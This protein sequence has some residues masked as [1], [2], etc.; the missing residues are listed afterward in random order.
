MKDKEQEKMRDLLVLAKD[1]ETQ[2][3]IDM[4]AYNWE[5][6]ASRMEQITKER[7]QGLFDDNGV[8]ATA[9]FNRMERVGT[10]M[11]ALKDRPQALL[12][13]G[14]REQLNKMNADH[15]MDIEITSL[16]SP[17]KSA[18]MKIETPTIWLRMKEMIEKK[19]TRTGKGDSFV[20]KLL[21]SRYLPNMEDEEAMDWMQSLSNP[22]PPDE[23]TERAQLEVMDAMAYFG[24]NIGEVAS[25]AR[26]QIGMGL[27]IMH[28]MTLL[29]SELLDI[30]KIADEDVDALFEEAKKELL[31]SDAWKSYWR[32]H[33][34]HLSLMKSS[35]L[36]EE[37]SKDADEV[38]QQLLDLHGYLYNKWDE[39]SE[40]FGKALKESD[41]GDDEMLRLLFLLAKK[42]AL[43]QE[44]ERP[45]N[46]LLIM[47]SKVKKYADKL[48]NLVDEKFDNI[49]DKV[50][51]DIVQNAIIGSQLSNFRKGRHNDGFNMQCFCH[52]VGW[53]QR[54]YHIYGNNAPLDL[55]KELGDR[56]SWETFK[57]YIKKRDVMLTA[58]SIKELDDILKKY[59]NK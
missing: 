30:R 47:R 41:M 1:Q 3:M 2:K 58:Q 48:Y 6:C 10:L 44:G 22:E 34:S 27:V 42:A 29:F 7:Q 59:T 19:K 25:A 4:M 56:Y 17:T 28:Q 15:R 13:K 55:G 8:E 5:V 20:R 45:D 36:A 16:I 14:F 37:L 51:D 52:I 9:V 46:N 53:M 32:G 12:L 18:E 39:S 11:V 23:E 35:S 38:E 57:D 26:Q 50:W 33:I 24:Q 21:K 31:E 43:E 49:Y 40:A 54:E